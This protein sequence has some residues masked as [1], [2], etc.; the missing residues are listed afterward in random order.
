M[1]RATWDE[2]WAGVARDVAKRSKC[3]RDQVGAV[4]VDTT[5]RIIATGYNGPPAWWK[6]GRGESCTTFCDRAARG[7][8]DE[9]AISYADCVSIHAEANALLFCDRN[10]RNEGTI[11]VTSHVCWTCAK[12]IANSALLRV[13]LVDVRDQPHRAPENSY[14]LLNECGIEV[15]NIF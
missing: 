11:Y 9:T 1:S 15:A 10:D 3:V 2:T 7:P 14:I 8:T 12:L 13:V 5:D 4:I 6:P